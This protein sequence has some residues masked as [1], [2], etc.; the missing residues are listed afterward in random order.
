MAMRLSFVHTRTVSGLRRL[1][2][3]ASQ[4]ANEDLLEPWLYTEALPDPFSRFKWNQ[5]RIAAEGQ[6][7]VTINPRPETSS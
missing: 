7:V 5:T 3:S 2:F 1:S 4:V 6:T